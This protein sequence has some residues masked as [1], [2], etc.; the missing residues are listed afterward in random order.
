MYHL[1]KTYCFIYIYIYSSTKWF[2]SY[3]W[4][5]QIKHY[6]ALEHLTLKSCNLRTLWPLVI[7][8]RNCGFTDTPLCFHCVQTRQFLEILSSSKT[9]LILKSGS[10]R[11]ERG[12]QGKAISH[13]D[14]TAYFTSPQH[15]RS[16]SGL[17]GVAAGVIYEVLRKLDCNWKIYCKL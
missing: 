9:T 2:G 15:A 8:E 16:S 12:S 3:A 11:K 4:M 10:S 6:Q 13:K 1:S 14:L 17:G 7:S 5:N